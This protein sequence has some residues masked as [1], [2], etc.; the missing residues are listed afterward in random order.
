MAAAFKA[1]ADAPSWRP[2]SPPRPLPPQQPG[3]APDG[4]RATAT[5]R[6]AAARAIA[7]EMALKPETC[8]ALYNAGLARLR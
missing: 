8:V 6:F 1:G 5:R 7:T 4:L 2:Q 3:R